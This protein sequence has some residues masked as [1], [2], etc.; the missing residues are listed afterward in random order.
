MGSASSKSEVTET[1]SRL[2][3]PRLLATS[4]HEPWSGSGVPTLRPNQTGKSTAHRSNSKHQ[5]LASI[6][7]QEHQARYQ[8]LVPETNTETEDAVIHFHLNSL[9]TMINQHSLNFYI[10][11]SALASREIGRAVIDEAIVRRIDGKSPFSPP[12]FY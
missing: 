4:L 12:L 11:S 10:T 9:A 1:Y 6:Q 7:Q 2:A 8:S 3:R 5:N